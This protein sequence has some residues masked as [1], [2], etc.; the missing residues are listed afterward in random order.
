MDTREEVTIAG[1][2]TLTLTRVDQEGTHEI[3]LYL[4]GA[5][6][7]VP[8]DGFEWKKLLDAALRDAT[9]QEDTNA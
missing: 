2:M 5:V 3:A 8:M 4:N 7:I 9:V 1:P 6:V